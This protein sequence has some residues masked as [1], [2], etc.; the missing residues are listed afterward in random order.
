MR[1]RTLLLLSVV[2]TVLP[3]WLVALAH[4]AGPSRAAGTSAPGR[5][6]PTTQARALAV[7]HAWDRHRARAWATG[8]PAALSRLYAPGSATGARDVGDLRLWVRRGVRVL[9]LRQQVASFRVA[10][11]TR[12]RLVVAVTERTVD[13]VAVGHGRRFAIPVSGWTRHR[14][15]MV[16]AG[17]RWRVA[18][19]RPQPAR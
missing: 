17:S 2:A 13:G 8:D 15:G 1:V 6:V 5:R 10:A 3:V 12:R 11:R 9:G 4:D 19:V 14:I 7:L 18:E 16:R